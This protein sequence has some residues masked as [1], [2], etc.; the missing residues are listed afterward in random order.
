MLKKLFILFIIPLI[1]LLAL[2]FLIYENYQ[3]QKN[4]VLNTTTKS[5]SSQYETIN[6]SF[7]QLADNTFHGYIN[8]AHIVD[9]F[10]R[11]DRTTLHNLLKDDYKKLTTFGFKQVQF[12]LPT[13]DSFLRLHKPEKFGDNLTDIRYSVDFVNK[14]KTPM[15]GLE[16]G[17]VLPGFRYVY[18]LFDKNQNHIGSVETSIGVDSF[19]KEIE[20]IYNVNSHF[21]VRKDIFDKKVFKD[22][23]DSYAPSYESKN[24]VTLVREDCE[25]EEL[26]YTKETKKLINENINQHKTF[27]METTSHHLENDEHIHKIITFLEL[28]NVQKQHIGYFVFYKNSDELEHLES[29]L[30]EHTIQVTILIFFI[31]IFLYREY[32]KKE[33]LEL[34]VHNKTKDL[35]NAVRNTEELNDEL[36]ESNLLL[37]RKSQELEQVV[38]QTEEMNDDLEEAN[39]LLEQKTQELAESVRQTEEL[40]DELEESNLILDQRVHEEIIKN[41]EKDIRAFEQA[42]MASMGEMIANIAHQWRQPLNSIASFAS[43]IKLNYELGVAQTKDIPSSMTDIIEKTKYLSETIDTFRDFIKEKKEKKEV[44]I[45]DRISRALSIVEAT[46]KSNFITLRNNI[47]MDETIK[48]TLVV[49]ELT[50]VLINI[51]NNAKDVLVEK[52]KE[53][54]YIELN[55]L[56]VVNEKVIITIE[57]NGGGIPD[58]ILPKI[59]DPYFTTKHQSQGTG[60]GLH[61]SYKIITESLNG[62][63]YAKNT[64]QG[65]KFFIELPLK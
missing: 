45:Q 39:L 65:A 24:Y 46:L 33:K 38:R 29:E 12:H 60:L 55:L 35:Q 28:K 15:T 27:S 57:D 54:R 53:C 49:G 17:R 3:S 14:N 9:T 36:E 42:K 34:E 52:D 20:D 4:R 30:I 37:Q 48:I 21:L 63:L 32:T 59:F 16:T 13:N 47:D 26:K 62:K 43:G 41:R 31:S 58:D 61:M 2:L 40:N 56:H 22:S 8:R 64:E 50:Q 51:L 7:K 10:M 18:P 5:I 1:I 11:R 6:N 19:A 25:N 23:A 44:V